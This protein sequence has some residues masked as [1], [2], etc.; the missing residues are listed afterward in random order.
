MTQNPACRTVAAGGVLCA[1]LAGCSGMSDQEKR[2]IGKYYIPA[3]SDTRPLIELNNDNRAV[4]RAIRPGELSFFVTGV[5]KVR[6]DSLI[7]EN[8][9]SSITIED[10]DAALIGD[11]APRVAYPIL[12]YDETVLSLDRGGI[13]Y[14]YH[15]RPE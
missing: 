8:D 15:R 10:G 1:L 2:M 12:S 7:I 9:A 13:V 5:W 14:D 6:D 3:V 4:I 11:V